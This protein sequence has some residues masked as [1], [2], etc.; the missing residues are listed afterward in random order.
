MKMTNKPFKQRFEAKFR[1]TPGCWIWSASTNC[2]GYGQI[3]RDGKM[4]GAH[5]VAY[6]LYVG[7]I[8]VGLVVRHKC[9]NKLCVNPD[10]LLAGTCAENSQDA[11]DRGL[12]AKG[13]D[14]GSCKLTEAQV[15]A[16]RS[17]FRVLREIATDYGVSRMQ[18]SDIKRKKYWLHL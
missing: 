3:R 7:Q 4:V 18:I 14:N 9:D 10:R 13:T 15:L 1:V 8:P 5:R 16:I 17:D 6:G 2:G 12:Y 11:V